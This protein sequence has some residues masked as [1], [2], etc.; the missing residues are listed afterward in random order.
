MLNEF[1]FKE[2]IINLYDAFNEC[3]SNLGMNYIF[4]LVNVDQNYIEMIKKM[5]LPSES[6][7][8]GNQS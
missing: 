5:R 2:I 8:I 4:F 7:K 6:F 1:S 3:I